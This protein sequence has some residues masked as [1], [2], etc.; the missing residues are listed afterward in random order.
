MCVWWSSC[1]S[2]NAIFYLSLSWWMRN[3]KR[4]IT[5]NY[6]TRINTESSFNF[7]M[8]VLIV[9]FPVW[10]GF[11]VHMFI[12]KIFG[13][14]TAYRNQP[15]I[16]SLHKIP[17]ECKIWCALFTN[18]HKFTLCPL[19]LSIDLYHWARRTSLLISFGDFV[20]FVVVVVVKH[21]IIWRDVRVY[22]KRSL[23]F[24]IFIYIFK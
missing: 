3:Q 13:M 17:N 6:P 5:F 19:L 20:V 11:V 4:F 2:C 15:T 14:K 18:A 8:H 1:K 7:R 23:E 10:F 22:A 24:K 9:F 12:R 16:E 21:F